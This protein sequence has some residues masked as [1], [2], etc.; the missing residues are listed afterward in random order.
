MEVILREHVDNLGR[1]GEIVKV[2]NG[3]ARNFLLPRKL[4][5]RATE[6]NRKQIE[7]ERAKFETREAEE[8]KVAEAIAEGL[9]NLSIS[10][11]RKV[12]ES[13][14]LYGSVTA[15][16]IAE[17]LAAKGF[18]VDRRKLQLRDALK[19][20]G[21]F[22]V[23]VKLHRDVTATLKVHVVAEGSDT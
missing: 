8:R 3:Y 22:D 16:D 17:A 19:K 6:G 11:A 10:V 1:R 9:A 14:V 23:P 13:D 4:A 7:R 20:L 15:A 21:E 18:E 2:A 5:L 12:G